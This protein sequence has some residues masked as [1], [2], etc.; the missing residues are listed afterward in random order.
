[1]REKTETESD[2]GQDQGMKA[3][4]ITQNFLEHFPPQIEVLTGGEKQIR[5]DMQT[6]ARLERPA[7][8]ATFLS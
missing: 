2:L 8:V 5:R 3:A 1:M 6:P 4:G 7:N